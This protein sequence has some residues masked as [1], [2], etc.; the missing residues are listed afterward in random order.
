MAYKRFSL[1]LAIRLFLA[2][3]AITALAW[4]VIEGV[5]YGATLLAIGVLIVM[6]VELWWFV[7]RTNREVARFLN[8]ARSADFSQRFSMEDVGSGFREL[9]D[10]FTDILNRIRD[11]RAD[12]AVELHRM[13]ALIDHIPVPLLTL[14]GDDSV[15]LQNNASR[16]L[17]GVSKVMQLSD[18]KQF[19]KSFHDAVS[20][21]VPGQREL[22]TFTVDG[23]E[24]QLTLA[25]TENIVAGKYR[26][27]CQKPRHFL[28]RNTERNKSDSNAS[29]AGLS[30]SSDARDHEFDHSCYFAGIDRGGDGRRYYE[31]HR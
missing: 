21:A 6:A 16:R 3:V 29:L 28:A 12:Q 24:Y 31:A 2:G 25:A 18:L 30:D 9:G 15:T 5:Y 11:E 17:F 26:G 23:V 10:V 22:V 27:R 8:A 19:G 14:H 4:L 20:E 7:N 13:S 1:G